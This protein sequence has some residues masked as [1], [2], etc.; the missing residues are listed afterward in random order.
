MPIVN[1]RGVN[2]RYEV[3]GKGRPIVFH[4]GFGNCLEDYYELGYVDA[5]KDEYQLILMDCRGFG[6]SD[7][8]H[9]SR[10][11]TFDIRTSDTI[12]VMDALGIDQAIAWGNSMGGRMVYALMQ[13]YP[14][15]FIAYCAGG[16]HPYLDKS[17]MGKNIRDWLSQGMEHAVDTF[18]QTYAPFPKN[19]R[20]RYLKNDPEAMRAAYAEPAPDFTEALKQIKSPVLLFCGETEEYRSEMEEVAKLIQN[21]EIQIIKGLDHC[22][23][24][25]Q[26][27][28][29]CEYIKRFLSHYNPRFRS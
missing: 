18:E 23:T 22:E 3:E 2:I 8:P 14:E 24:Y 5:L 26:G 21:G 4:H 19:L 13:Y 6:Q 25:W 28:K 10:S 7:K 29:V 27:E 20:Q 11:Y 12:A 15:R 9:D 16:M 17:E 1:N